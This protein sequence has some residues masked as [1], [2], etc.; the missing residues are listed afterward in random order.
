MKRQGRTKVASLG[1]IALVC[2]SLTA[3]CETTCGSCGV[4]GVADVPKELAKVSLPPYVVEPPDILLLDVVRVVPL[5]PY[6]V[7]PLDGL[8]IQATE[9][10]PAE[11]ISG[12]FVVDPNGMV[13]L[14]ASYG[15]VRVVDMTLD[16][17]KTAVDQRLKKV[18]RNSQVTVSLAQSRAGQQIRGEHLVRPD[19]M[20]GL[21]L[22]GGVYVAGKTLPEVKAAVEQHLAQY[23]Y[24]PEVSVDVF[25]Y[26]SKVYYV[27]TDGAGLGEQV[28]RAPATGNETVLDAISQINGLPPVSDKDR[29]WIARPAPARSGPDQILPVDWNAIVRGGRTETN[30]QVFPGDRIYVKSRPI[31]EADNTIARVI[32]PIERLFGITLLGNSTVRSFRNNNGNG[33]GNNSGF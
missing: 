25:A 17:A 12:V 33:N 28:L 16:E 1:V 27:V 32:S 2:C 10:L 8:F 19:G 24:K 20:I 29:V 31:V 5:P 3:G 7:E 15:S 14:G 13:S 26:N 9:T 4:C 22:Y 6:K 21:G 23:L 11:P 18:L 30:Y